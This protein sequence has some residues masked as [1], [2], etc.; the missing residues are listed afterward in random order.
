LELDHIACQESAL[1]GLGHWAHSY[2]ERVEKI[3]DEFLTHNENLRPELK[4]YALQAR[5]GKVQ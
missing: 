1:H 3:V 4:Q 2:P 5:S